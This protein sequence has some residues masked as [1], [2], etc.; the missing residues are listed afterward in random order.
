MAKVNSEWDKSLEFDSLEELY[1]YYWCKELQD[2]NLLSDL[3][4]GSNVRTFDLLSNTS[5]VWKKQLKTKVKT[6]EFTLLQKASYTPDFSFKLSKVLEKLL[7]F[8]EESML[9]RRELWYLFLPPLQDH[10]Y[11]EIKPEFEGQSSSVSF[12]YKQK[13]VWDKHYVYTQKVK[14]L[15][16]KG[17]FSKTFCPRYYIEQEVYKKPNKKKNIRVGDSKIK[18]KYLTINEWLKKQKVEKP[19]SKS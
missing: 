3:E 8:S 9:T 5:S 15:G 18:F 14:P 12:P 17:L 11:I 10:F 16:V 6:N 2:R 4:Y 19:G 1:F 13:W 7:W